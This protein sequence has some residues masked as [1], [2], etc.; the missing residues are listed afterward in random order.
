MAPSQLTVF[1]NQNFING[2]YY[3]GTIFNG[4]E[5]PNELH[6]YAK[7]QEQINAFIQLLANIRGSEAGAHQVIAPL[8]ASIN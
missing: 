8:L 4:D 7:S 1:N 6:F 2:D 5:Y 3:G